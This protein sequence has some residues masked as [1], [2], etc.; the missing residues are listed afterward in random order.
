ME[1]RTY[2]VAL[3][4]ETPLLLHRDNLFWSEVMKKWQT[5]PANKAISTKG[6]DRTPAWRWIGCLYHENDRLIIPS[7]NLMTV[8]REGGKRCPTGKGQQTFKSQSQSGLVV[9]QSG[10]PL[11]VNGQEILYGPIKALINEPDFD[12]HE[13]LAQELGFSL[14]VKR[15]GIKSSKH[16]RV[17]PRFDSWSCS[18]TITVFDEMITKEVLENI[19]RFAGA[20]SGLGD[21]R[22]SAP[23]S[24]G[25][26]GKFTTEVKLLKANNGG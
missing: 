24:P 9:D 17:R 21:W 19:L 22:P 4:G 2:A 15:A 18:G 25:P 13:I 8:I 23:K 16:V 7:D 14:F 1:F 6:D 26:W 12:L 3:K 20:Y 5:D 11:L 10:W